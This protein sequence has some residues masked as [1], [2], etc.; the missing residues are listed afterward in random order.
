MRKSQAII[1]ECLRR[2]LWEVDFSPLW[3]LNGYRWGY[4]YWGFMLQF[5]QPLVIKKVEEK[6]EVTLAYAIFKRVYECLTFSGIY[7]PMI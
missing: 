1:I 5:L 4:R 6:Q 2:F 7:S 3:S